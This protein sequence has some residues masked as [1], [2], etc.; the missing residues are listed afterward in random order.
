MQPPLVFIEKVI[1]LVEVAQHVDEVPAIPT[2]LPHPEVD[3]GSLGQLANIEVG[4]GVAT[5]ASRKRQQLARQVGGALDGMADLLKVGAGRVL[6]PERAECQVEISRTDEF[7]LGV[8]APVR[9]S[10]DVAN[11]PGITLEGPA[12]SIT[13]AKGLICARR[14]IHMHPDDALHFG[15]KDRDVVEV[16][17]DSEGRDLIFGDVLVRVS[18]KFKLEMHI[19]TDEANAA[20]IVP[21][22]EG[23]LEDV[24]RSARLRRRR[25][26]ND[27]L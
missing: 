27:T 5:K 19:D 1:L 3:L 9:D 25:V 12:G 4:T 2:E 14:H 21:G 13:L 20:M 11:S 16:E 17:V 8:D 6:G 10:G 7:T 24:S 18:P 15:V 26:S 23:V 22:A